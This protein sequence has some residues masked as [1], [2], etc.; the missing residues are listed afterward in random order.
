M[1]GAIENYS[2]DSSA[3]MHPRYRGSDGFRHWIGSD[4]FRHWERGRF[5]AGF[6]HRNVAFSGTGILFLTAAWADA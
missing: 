2:Q 6:R 5:G 3:R 4:G 1:Q